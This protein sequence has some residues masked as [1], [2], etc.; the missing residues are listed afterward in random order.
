M[1]KIT[2]LAILLFAAGAILPV[3]ASRADTELEKGQKIYETNCMLCHGKNGKGDGPAA[4]LLNPKPADYTQPA[5]WASDASK[6]IAATIKDGKGQMPPFALDKESV[7][8]VIDY[9]EH[10]FKPSSE[11]KP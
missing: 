3:R 8:A 9:L 7:Q 6:K 10:T 5:F 4:A 2:A 11:S 1:K